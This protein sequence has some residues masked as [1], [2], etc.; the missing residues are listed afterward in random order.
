M[1]VYRKAVVLSVILTAFSSLIYFVDL[2]AFLYRASVLSL[3]EHEAFDG[4][5]YPIEL[6]PN[7]VKL[8]E[9]ERKMKFGDLSSDKL[10]SIPYYDPNVFDSEHGWFELE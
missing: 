9:A 5:V 3:P 4:T 1:Q 6:V 8:T 7:Y 2:K 10:M